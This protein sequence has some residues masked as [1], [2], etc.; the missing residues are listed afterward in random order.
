VN[1]NHSNSPA[2]APITPNTPARAPGFT[3]SLP[4]GVPENESGT[5]AGKLEGSFRLSRCPR[6]LPDKAESKA[7]YYAIEPTIEEIADRL[8]EGYHCRIRG[9]FCDNLDEITRALLEVPL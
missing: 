8:E 9:R 2:S 4:I 7:T 5:I 3:P 1:Q 6:P